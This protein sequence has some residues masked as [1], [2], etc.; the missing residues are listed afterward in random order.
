MATRIA[1]AGNP[2]AGKTTLFNLLTG[3]NQYVGNWPGVTVE[4]KEGKLKS[5]FGAK[6]EVIITDLPGI[7]SLSPYTLEEVVTRTYI[8]DEQP[9]AIINIIDGTNLERNLYLTTQLAELGVPMVVAVNMM[10]EVKKRGD[11]I[12]VATLSERLG[13][14]VVE[15]SALKNEGIQGLVD[16]TMA[17]GSADAIV[18]TTFE[19]GVEKALADIAEQ[20]PA[21]VAADQRRWYSIKLFERDEKIVDA[22]GLSDSAKAAVEKIITATEDAADDDSESLITCGRY[23]RIEGI[24]E[25][26]LKVKNK[27]QLTTSD[28]IDRVVTNRIL[29][30]PI[31]V[32]IMFLVYYISVSTVGS[33][34]TGWA[35]DGVFGDGWFLDPS[36][37]VQVDG[38]QV[39]FDEV[40][41]EYEN[42][43]TVLD[44]GVGG[45]YDSYDDETG[46]DEFVK[47]DQ[48]AYDEAVAVVESYGETAEEY[49]EAGPDPSDYGIWIPGIPALLENFFA[50]INFDTDSWVYA[51]IMDGIIAGVGAVLGFVPQMMIL[52]IL[53]A[54]LESCGYLAR[55]AFVLDRIF[56]RFGLSGKS[57]IPLLIGSG[58]GVPGI[59]ASRTIENLADRRMTIMTV[60]FIPCGAKLPVIALF[61]GAI[62]GGAWWV[63]PSAY[64]LGIATVLCSGIILKKTKPFA[65]EAAPFVMELPAYHLPTVG[66]VLRSM[67]ERAWA[68]IKKACTILLLACIVIW[69][70][71]TYGFEDG[72]FCA[73]SDTSFSLLA[74]IGSAFAWIFIPLGFGDWQAAAASLSGLAAKEDIVATLGILYAG[75]TGNWYSNFA[76]TYGPVAA[77]AFMAFNLICVP[78]F[79][80][81]TAAAREHNSKKWFWAQVGYQMGVAWLIALWVFNFGGLI[82]GEAPLS[83]WT[84]L[85]AVTFVGFLYLLFRP[86]KY[87]GVKSQNAVKAQIESETK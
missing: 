64:F 61:A 71:S 65:G 38:A 37:I 50:S 23:D 43:V 60:T 53:L 45:S 30:L 84:A 86:N 79:A 68:F 47:V 83:I 25:G 18:P 1:L 58:C 87:K 69:F 19:E 29:G 22:L 28:K 14:P 55:V 40:N 2:N 54:I 80:A 31:F 51:L 57:F 42:A 12:D 17:H 16:A 13:M 75:D 67:W 24:V 49:G 77:Y 85:A 21:S 4:K 27:G 8:L 11:E 32:V 26:A 46:E 33:V 41:D 59:M 15:I 9:E 5:S 78:C 76:N 72:S 74:G 36:P 66:G 81:L 56:R 48:D 63:A 39:A 34:A 62:Y 70:L 52:F 44:T 82:S 3:A 7:Y 73:V 20:L 35:N 6:D 10:D